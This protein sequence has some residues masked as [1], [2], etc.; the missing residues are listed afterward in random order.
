[1][2]RRPCSPAS[3][4]SIQ[5]DNWRLGLELVYS[6]GVFSRPPADTDPVR[7]A[8]EKEVS[9]DAAYK[10]TDDLSLTAKASFARLAMTQGSDLY[11]TQLAFPGVTYKWNETTFSA[12]FLLTS[13]DPQI[14]LPNLPFFE[15][16]ASY[17]VH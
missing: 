17:A 5:L 4:P 13:L 10:L 15:V 11:F 14:K 7:E 8:S 12:S 2:R 16:G 6:V 9:V 3:S 1:M